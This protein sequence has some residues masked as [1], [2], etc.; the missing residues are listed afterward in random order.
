MRR[1]RQ[2]TRDSTQGSVMRLKSK[3]NAQRTRDAP[4]ASKA[5]ECL[6]IQSPLYIRAFQK[7]WYRFNQTA[8]A[9]AV[10][11]PLCLNFPSLPCPLR[12][13]VCLSG[14][15]ETTLRCEGLLEALT[16]FGKAVLMVMGQHNE[17]TRIKVSQGKRRAGQHP[18]DT[19]PGPPVSAPSRAVRVAPNSH[20]D[21]V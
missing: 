16:E 3:T 17:R 8:G 7:F 11:F 4:N 14:V 20:G 1:E 21:D 12:R 9:F 18:R 13:R 5:F 15:P 10:S 2:S 19:R 6:N